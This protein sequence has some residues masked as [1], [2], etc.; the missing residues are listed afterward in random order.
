LSGQCSGLRTLP[1]R[2]RWHCLK[3]SA[4]YIPI[5]VAVAITGETQLLQ[6][7]GRILGLSRST[8]RSGWISLCRCWNTLRLHGSTLRWRRNAL[9]LRRNALRAC[10][11]SLGRCG[12]A[13]RRGSR[14]ILWLSR[15]ILGRSRSRCLRR[16]ILCL[17][18]RILGRRSLRLRRLARGLHRSTL[19]LS[20][21]HWRTRG[22]WRARSCWGAGRSR[23]GRTAEFGQGSVVRPERLDNSCSTASYERAGPC[24]S[25][26]VTYGPE[27][28]SA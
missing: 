10:W 18:W 8:L 23:L 7:Y 27:N 15:R 2:F 5:T 12:N 28:P 24:S 11:I 14:N 26:A 3:R 6:L 1:L 16:V 9:R 4:T 25:A 13:L 17:Y 20:S 19:R 22:G 21:Y